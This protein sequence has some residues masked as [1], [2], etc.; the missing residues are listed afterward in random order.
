MN[1][2]QQKWFALEITAN[3]E[4]SEAVEFAL[5]ELDALGTEINNLGKITPETLKYYR[6][7]PR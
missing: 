1:S 4:V 2:N 6:L 7:F 3:A 5:N